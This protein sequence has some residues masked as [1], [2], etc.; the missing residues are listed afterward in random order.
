MATDYGADSI[1]EKKP[2]GRLGIYIHVPFCVRKCNYCDFCSAV[3]DEKEIHRYAQSLIWEISEYAK[4]S[5]VFKS[6]SEDL[7]PAS[8]NKQAYASNYIVDSIY[9]G[10]G[11]PSVLPVQDFLNIVNCLKKNF[12]IDSSAEFTVEVNPRTAN[13]EKLA[14]YKENGVN[15]IS[16][17]MQSIHENELKILGRIHNYDD[18]LKT[19]TMARACG[20]SNINVD[21]MYGIP[22]QTVG[23]FSKTIATLAA[24]CPEHISCYGLMVEEGTPFYKNRDALAFPGEDEE[25]M[26]YSLAAEILKERGY[27]HYEI[28][29]YSKPGCECR[30]NLKYWN[31]ED[32][33]GFGV[34]A[35][36]YFGGKRFYNTSI[37]KEY[38]NSGVAK[39][40]YDETDTV[41]VCPSEYIMLKLR[42][43]AGLNFEEY[44]NLFNASFIDGRA[45]KLKRFSELGLAKL[46][47]SSFALTEKGFY[48]SNTIISELL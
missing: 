23:N 14:L 48:V 11:T 47:D 27:S 29:N 7:A 30:H 6:S 34:S 26:M 17:G 44:E 43:S 45:P 37:I 13:E 8:D 40:R 16:I 15:R 35:H 39:Y 5:G 33:L 19:Y 42:L 9:F 31:L 12:K 18:F 25:V 28:S 24:L 10:G 2:N 20:F 22:E 1:V 3:A 38:S 21:V 36:S 41:G 32:Y 46:T 4:A